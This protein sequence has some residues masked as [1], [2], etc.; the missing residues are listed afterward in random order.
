MNSIESQFRIAA[1][2]YMGCQGGDP[3]AEI[4]LCGREEG[5]GFS[6]IEEIK[7]AIKLAIDRDIEE[8]VEVWPGIVKHF[9]GDHGGHYSALVSWIVKNEKIEFGHYR[10]P[11][12]DNQAIEKQLGK[13]FKLNLYPLSQADSDNFKFGSALGFDSKNEDYREWCARNRFPKLS[14]LI[15]IY[16]PRIVICA[17][18]TAQ[19]DFKFAFGLNDGH[20][21]YLNGKRLVVYQKA[22]T[23]FF[24]TPA[25][26]G[27]SSGLTTYSD[28]E[29][30]GKKIRELS[31]F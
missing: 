6:S 27:Q 20:E 14:N 30:F 25:L 21:E 29:L 13:V 11:S 2:N 15:S 19:E 17:Q 24:I 26:S 7:Q 23:Q 31:N 4:W 9:K 12:Y 8:P 28:V 18:L 3:K 1:G 10:Q 22:G 5:E 16:A